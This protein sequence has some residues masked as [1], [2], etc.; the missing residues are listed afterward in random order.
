[1][2]NFG[3]A[4]GQH[5]KKFITSLGKKNIYCALKTCCK[6]SY[7]PQNATAF[8]IYFVT[9]NNI[10]VFCKVLKFKYELQCADPIISMYSPSFHG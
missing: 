1:M 2:G 9:S 3:K 4:E 7:F 6:I 8:I 10:P 5:P